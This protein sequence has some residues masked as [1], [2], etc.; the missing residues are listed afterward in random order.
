MQTEM[1]GMLNAASSDRAELRSKFENSERV[2]RETIERMTKLKAMI[3]DT[4]PP[5]ALSSSF[6]SQR[7]IQN[8]SISC[9]SGRGGA[10]PLTTSGTSVWFAA[11]EIQNVMSASMSKKTCMNGQMGFLALARKQGR[12]V[13][14]DGFSNIE[15]LCGLEKIED[16]LRKTNF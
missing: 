12:S 5:A 7:E 1:M 10:P 14:G 13:D 6:L 4:Q 2:Q 9:R 8:T 11:F 15:V 16:L 3:I